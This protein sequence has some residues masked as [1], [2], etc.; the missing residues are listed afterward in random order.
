MNRRT[1]RSYGRCS[2]CTLELVVKLLSLPGGLR[3]VFV[4]QYPVK[5][6][7]ECHFK[8]CFEEPA[9]EAVVVLGSPVQQS[10]PEHFYR[11]H[12]DKNGQ[13]LVAEVLLK[14]DPA[15]DVHIKNYVFTF[16]PDPFNL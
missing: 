2:W 16:L 15:L 7:L 10:L 5:M 11:R 13:G 6:I 9:R 1:G 4:H 14:V 12:F 3:Q 8:V